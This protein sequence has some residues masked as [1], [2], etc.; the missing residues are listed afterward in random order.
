MRTRES[1]KELWHQVGRLND[2][3]KKGLEEG[4]SASWAD[5]LIKTRTAT[6]HAI[7]ALDIVR[8]GEDVRHLRRMKAQLELPEE[9]IDVS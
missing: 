8:E 1:I 2:R 6:M 4:R 9:V 5:C 3:I 7:E